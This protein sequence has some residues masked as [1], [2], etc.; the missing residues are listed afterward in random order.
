VPFK[1]SELDIETRAVLARVFEDAWEQLRVM[2]PLTAQPQ[3]TRAAREELAKRISE[4]YANGEHD[5]EALKLI[6]LKAF[7]R[8][9]T[10]VPDM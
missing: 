9:I 4:G 5:P 8:W 6:A 10:E 7:N 3:N 1:Q 2:Q